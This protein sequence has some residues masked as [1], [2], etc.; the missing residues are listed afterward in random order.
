[1]AA[2]RLVETHLSLLLMSDERVLKWKKPVAFEFVDLRTLEARQRICRREVELNRRLAPD[3]YEGVAELRGPGGEL[4]EPVVVMRR[5]PEE[6]RLATLVG[7]DDPSVTDGLGKLAQL[8]AAFHAGADRSAAIAAQGRA[9]AVTARWEANLRQ[10]R[11]SGVRLGPVPTADLDAVERLATAWLAGR[12]P[13]LDSRAEAGYVVDGHGDLQ[14]DDVFLLEQGPAVI[15]C[16][17]FDDDLR[18]VDVADDI[19]FLAMDLEHLGR[20][21]LA[22]AFVDAYDTASARRGLDPLPRHLVDVWAAY[23]AVVRAMVTCLRA[24]QSDPA[25]PEHTAAVADVA[26]LLAIARR[27]LEAA[28][29]RVVLVGGS[30]GT[31]KSKLARG[32]AAA[33]SWPV[34]R[35]DEIRE[36][37]VVAVGPDR[38]YEPAEVD[39]VYAAVLERARP[40]LARGETVV[41]DATWGSA[42]RRARARDL[43]AASGARL[44]EVRCVVD[45]ETAASRVAARAA[46]GTDVSE[47]T[48]D[49][50]RRLAAEFDPWAEAIEVDTSGPATTT[51]GAALT[52]L[53]QVGRAPV[54]VGRPLA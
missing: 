3:V 31:G 11:D 49:V 36:E 9:T 46:R 19:A 44:I 1:V 30:P 5:L 48:P 40:L 23:R 47:A 17:E 2:T 33:H 37:V 41:L 21:D 51:L 8:M 53:G 42:A 43:A 39:R 4:W 54:D 35:S 27:R 32:L 6:R 28:E 13:L 24:A 15:D 50:A 20:A 52:A 16:L 34:V 14:A 7:G 45:A 29:V 10:L 18:A 38:R 26:L 12:G 22:S 25:T